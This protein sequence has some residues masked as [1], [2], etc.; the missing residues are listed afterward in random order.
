ME[1]HNLEWKQT[2]HDEYLNTICGFANA[3]GGILE[4]GRHKN[5]EI[6]GVSNPK[7][8]LED[9]PN[10]TKSAMGIIPTIEL[11]QVNGKQYLTITVQKYTFPV[12]C[13]GKYYI[14]SGTTT[15]ELNG[16]QLDT[17]MLKTL[18]K[19]WDGV[20]IPQVKLEDF[21]SDAFKAFRKMAIGSNRMTEADLRINDK[22]LLD[23]LNLTEPNYLKRAAIML[24]HQTPEQYVIGTSVKIGYFKTAA[25]LS[26]QDEI[27]GPLITLADKVVNLVYLKYFKGFISYKGIHRIETYPIPRSAF[28]EAVLN[29]IVHKDYSTGNPIHIHIY[30]NKVLI[31]ND[32]KLPEN[33]TIKDL[34]TTHTS[35]PYN[36][37][38]A[39][40]FFRSGQIEAWGRGIEKILE[41]CKEQ[42]MPKPFFRIR[43]N[44]VM[45]GFN[46]NNTASQETSQENKDGITI[47]QS[48][49]LEL[50]RSN[51]KITAK[52]IA[53]EIGIAPRNVQAH[54][55]VLKKSGLIERVGSTKRGQW[56]AKQYTVSEKRQCPNI[57]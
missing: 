13:N 38:I 24:F 16:P 29:A 47:L 1:T 23:N 27:H 9:L 22:M 32:G 57:Q 12:S 7:K 40:T 15:Q 54:I 43:P 17:F 48:R 30:K 42:N 50:M 49:V 35:K 14:R 26:Y 41:A 44:E 36:P 53:K 20:P 39:N 52:I 25:D 11:Q 21:E 46:T 8:L 56:I 10:K 28:R 51:P 5:G 4:I 18:G 37:L 45:I 19:T 55:S 6:I 31:Y 33:W 3:D 34:F 2:W